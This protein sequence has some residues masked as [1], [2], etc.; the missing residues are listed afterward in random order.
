[1]ANPLLVNP[2]KGNW[3]NLLLDPDNQINLPIL[4]RVPLENNLAQ[5]NL[6]ANNLA[7][8]NLAAYNLAENN[9]AANL[10]CKLEYSGLDVPN[11][12][13]YFYLGHGGSVTK[14]NGKLKVERVPE[15]CIYITQTVCGVVNYM[16]DAIF[17]AF[18][19]KKNEDLWRDPV[20]NIKQINALFGSLPGVHIHYPKCTFIDTSFHP[21]SDNGSD[22]LHM[23]DYSGLIP[24]SKAQT[25]SFRNS[26]SHFRT[27]TQNS[28]EE[29]TIQG[30]PESTV[31]EMYRYAVY[32]E[33]NIKE[34]R[35]LRYTPPKVGSLY[36]SSE[37]GIIPF[38]S[39]IQG[40]K[41]LSNSV[42]VFDLMKRYP[43]IH[44]NFLCRSLKVSQNPE[45]RRQMTLRRRHSAV[46]QDTV[47][48]NIAKLAYTGHKYGVNHGEMAD[49]T[50]VLDLI[51]STEDSIREDQNLEKFY[52]TIHELLYL[53]YKKSFEYLQPI[54]IE[55]YLGTFYSLMREKRSLEEIK[56]FI[57]ILKP[58]ILFINQP[59]YVLEQYLLDR[60]A[61]F[62]FGQG[63]ASITRY[64]C[65]LG[66]PL[67][68]IQAEYNT[69]KRFFTAKTLR[70]RKR[71][72][73]ECKRSYGKARTRRNREAN[74]N[75]DGH[76]NNE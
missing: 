8:N 60:M 67:T 40:S 52:A 4:G 26:P 25:V 31:R 50:A 72:L 11:E 5:N 70:Q 74:N 42:T 27:Y 22:G 39:L 2:G 47:F 23:I 48:N 63:N 57:D 13:I 51:R 49:D 66:A 6:A 32:P 20:N 45:H 43:G 46:L 62:A 76:S 3:G 44:F 75:D 21:C 53:G 15:N 29:G 71:I 56:Q 73:Q 10:Q 61:T 14:N 24:L 38:Q 17:R 58:D 35:G 12:N 9:L 33:L 65:A 18:C 55:K 19:N 37:N 16:E 34:Q 68:G 28:V 36:L 1:M 30:I 64:T 7:A 69:I 54:F 59:M 41:A